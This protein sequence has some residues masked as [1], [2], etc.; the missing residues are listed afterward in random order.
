MIQE[1]R[2]KNFK[3]VQKLKLELGRVNVLIGANGCGKSNI[4]EAI[5]RIY[6][7]DNLSVPFV[8]LSHFNLFQKLKKLH[9]KFLFL[10]GT[11]CHSISSHAFAY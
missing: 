3:S 5:Y 1:I 2:I 6:T 10:C 7:L 4:L 11:F 9:L 8:F